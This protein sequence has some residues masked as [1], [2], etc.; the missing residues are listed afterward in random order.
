MIKRF[1]AGKSTMFVQCNAA[2]EAAIKA[3]LERAYGSK[4]TATEESVTALNSATAWDITKMT[5]S[6]IKE[7]KKLVAKKKWREV[8]KRHNAGEW[9]EIKYCCNRHQNIIK[10]N[11]KQ[12][13]TKS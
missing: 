4:V 3:Q 5:F 10:E 6:D 8:Y 9:S 11:L 13:A 1:T 12:I 7:V 2:Q